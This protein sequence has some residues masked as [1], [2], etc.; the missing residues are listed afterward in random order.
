[1]K[2]T[3]YFSLLAVCS[4]LLASCTA[5]MNSGGDASSHYERLANLP[6]PNA[7][8]TQEAADVL[9]EEL[10]FQRAV[11]SYLWSLPAMNMYAMREGQ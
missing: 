9:H 7:Q 8:P 6:F 11:Q 2:A 5:T 1:M 4:L 10:A 3:A